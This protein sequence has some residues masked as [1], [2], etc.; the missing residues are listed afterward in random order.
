MGITSEPIA[1]VS[2]MADPDMPPN[3]RQDTTV[4]T[5]RPPEENR[6]ESGRIPRSACPRRPGDKSSPPKI[7]NGTAIRMNGSTPEMKLRK[8]VSSGWPRSLAQII[9]TVVTSRAYMRGTPARAMTKKTTKMI[10]A[11]MAQVP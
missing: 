11:N 3:M 9:P 1:A 8:I 6:K 5:P 4:T 10:S 7:N 2:A